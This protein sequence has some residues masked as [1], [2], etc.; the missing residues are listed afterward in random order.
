LS[1]RTKEVADLKEQLNAKEA[2][3]KALEQEK[4]LLADTITGLIGTTPSI[5]V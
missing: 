2:E 4:K 3:L 5:H 1:E